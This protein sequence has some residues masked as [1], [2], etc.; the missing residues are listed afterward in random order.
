LVAAASSKL[1]VAPADSGKGKNISLLLIGDSSLEMRHSFPTHIYNLF[2]SPGNPVLKMIGENGPGWPDN[3]KNIRHEG[4]GGWSYAE[5]TTAGRRLVKGRSYARGNPF[6]NFKT[7][8]LDFSAYFQKNTEGKTPD[9][10]LISLG[11]NDVFAC[12]DSTLDAKLEQIRKQAVSLISAIRK[13]APETAVGVILPEYCSHSQD[14]FGRLYGCIQTRWQFKKNCFKYRSMME[15]LIR[16]SGD[17]CLFSVPCYTALDTVNNVH[18]VKDYINAR[19]PVP[20]L[21]ESNGLHPHDSGYGQ[22]ADSCYAWMKN[23]LNR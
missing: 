23:Q 2:Q 1:I 5:F 13:A 20:V 8:S 19:N 21:R 11:G 3:I 10:I 12:T 15:E 17:P 6:W 9:F 18:K 14:A 16:R 7:R 4:Y 22:L